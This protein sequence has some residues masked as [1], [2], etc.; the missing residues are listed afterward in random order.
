MATLA[1]HGIRNLW[2][3]CSEIN[4]HPSRARTIARSMA[5]P[6][7]Q[8][9]TRTRACAGA[10]TVSR[11][12]RP[13][14][15]APCCRPV[16]N[17]GWNDFPSFDD[18]NLAH[19][20]VPFRTHSAARLL[21]RYLDWA[22]Q[23]ARPAPDRQTFYLFLGNAFA[24][25][26]TIS[27]TLRRVDALGLQARHEAGCGH[28][29]HARL[30]CRWQ[31]HLRR[32]ALAVYARASRAAAQLDIVGPTFHF[33]PALVRQ[34]GSEQAVREFFQLRG[35]HLPVER[36]SAQTKLA[37]LSFAESVSPAGL[38]ALMRAARRARAVGPVAVEA[39]R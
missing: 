5:R 14:T 20:R 24:N 15:C 17:T 35:R 29:C 13:P 4:I 38:L 25:A 22:D 11:A 16:S 27:T 2:F 34:L 19:C 28:H 33:A 39:G 1:S 6:E 7:T 32:P 18:T 8:A 37:R 21:P 23:A 10:R 3:V 30:L 12:W 26:R 31:A 9:A 36:A